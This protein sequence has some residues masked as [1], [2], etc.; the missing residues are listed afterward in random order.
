MAI[1]YADQTSADLPVEARLLDA[2]TVSLVEDPAEVA[3]FDS[4]I[5]REHYLHTATSVG[6]VL[7]Y[8]AKHQDQWVGLLVFAS[9]AWHLKPRERWL[10]WNP[11][12]LDERRHL[13]AQNTRLLILP[14]T[15]Q[16][17][18]LA[19]R[20][21]S[22]TTRRL[23]QDWQARYG[24]PVLALETFVD[25]ERF[26]AT[27]YRAAGWIPLGA[28]RGFAR[29]SRDFYVDLEHPKELWVRA[30]SPEALEVLR[31][32]ELAPELRSPRPT[33]PA[34]VPLETEQLDSFWAYTRHHLKETR[35]PRGLRY[36]AHNLL[37]LCVLA[38]MAGA[39][40]PEAIH[41]FV[42]T[43]N[44]AQ[45]R[46][47]RCPPR[48]GKPREYDVPCERTI[49]RF[50][51]AA[52]PEQIRTVLCGWMARDDPAPLTDLYFD[53]KCLR[54][55][56]AQPPEP[57]AAQ[58]LAAAEAAMT[59]EIALAEQK[60]KADRCL[61]VVNFITPGQ[62]LHDQIAVP[63]HTNEE[64]ATVIH[65]PEMDLAG[66]RVQGDA[67][68][69]T[70]AGCRQLTQGNGADYLLRLKANQPTALAKAQQ[71]LPGGLPPSGGV[72]RQG[73]RPH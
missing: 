72:D 3:R 13:L 43:L 17:P 18:N 46:R 49:R 64:A 10:Q 41:E 66:V 11:S 25:P 27:C 15:G 29:I 51:G 63:S 55:A 12:R 45:R 59:A 1:H 19:S 7:R 26:K 70:K 30:L 5:E 31:A 20:I 16:W 28:T 34:P 50:L 8:V 38:A 47:L 33:P 69:A 60:P 53:G 6:A 4:L 39:Y 57:E 21:L 40:T 14:S 71:I 68:H 24:T 58:A 67:A 65:W 2:I 62:R 52:T 35:Q 73:P 44:H 56:E 36:P 37:C 9:P 61:C 42:T 54:S 22:L 48:T 32:P 23:S